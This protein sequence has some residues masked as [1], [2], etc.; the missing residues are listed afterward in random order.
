MNNI[1]IY[2]II[3]KDRVKGLV[4]MMVDIYI[5]SLLFLAGLFLGMISIIYGI[6]GVLKTPVK[7]GYCNICNSSYR[8][9][10]LIPVISYFIMR[11]KCRYCNNKL[12]LMY[13]LL[14]ILSGLLFSFSYI[15][16]GFSYEMIIMLVLTLLL[17]N[18]F[19]SDFKYFIILDK[20]LVFFSVVVL[21][22][23]YVFF[24]FETFVI[25]VC[26]GILIFLFMVAI[27]FIGDKIFK[28]ESLGGGD[29]KLS[30]FFGFLLGLRLS[31]VSLIV[32]SF[33][34]FPYAIYSALNHM[35]KEIPFGPFLI[36]GLFLVFLF[37]DV[38]NNFISI[39]F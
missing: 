36:S 14:E 26:S 35:R 11:G 13:P 23:K 33:L 24:G 19:V 1:K 21:F 20:P 39:I 31:I 7:A 29:I 37:M 10:E 9:S 5:I 30:V 16:Y 17:I 22:L 2:D 28:G 38:V 34:A 27:K 32:G 6:K 15:I 18:I 12:S 4:M 3:S 25:S 8:W